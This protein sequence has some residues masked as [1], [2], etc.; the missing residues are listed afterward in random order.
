[1]RQVCISLRAQSWW[2]LSR[3][4]AC[5]SDGLVGGGGAETATTVRMSNKNGDGNGRTKLNKV[6]IFMVPVKNTSAR[7][8]LRAE[9]RESCLQQAGERAPGS[10]ACRHPQGP[11]RGPRA[12]Q[13]PWT[14]FCAGRLIESRLLRNGPA[15]AACRPEPLEW[16]GPARPG[17]AAHSM[18]LPRMSPRE[19]LAQ[20][21]PDVLE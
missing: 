11:R 6:A 2:P 3:G 17:P 21:G 7:F 8:V 18:G 10:P 5:A 9:V 15:C 14:P 12:E 20:P 13:R 1:M 19:P 4:V 16:A